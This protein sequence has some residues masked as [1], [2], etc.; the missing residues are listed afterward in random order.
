MKIDVGNR[1]E[2]CEPTDDQH[3]SASAEQRTEKIEEHFH[4]LGA[5]P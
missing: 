3:L 2:V 4:L 5:L 1:S